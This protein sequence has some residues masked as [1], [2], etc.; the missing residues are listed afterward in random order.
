MNRELKSRVNEHALMVRHWVEAANSQRARPRTEKLDGWCA[1]A[2]AR[3][4]K[5]LD[6]IG[7]KSEIHMASSDI[8]SHVYLV[9][10]DHVVDV[11]ATQFSH[12]RNQKVVIAHHRE[13][14]HHWF[15]QSEDIFE[16]ARELQRNQIR[17]G[18]PLDQTAKV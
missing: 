11:T 9:V 7:I 3:L 10:E 12:F 16:T 18:W 15:Y 8:G 6:D 17:T 13:V 1:I 14:D 4:W 5:N 2:T